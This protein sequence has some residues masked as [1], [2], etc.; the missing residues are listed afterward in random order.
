MLNL[1]ELERKLDLAL[2]NET[3]ESLT[4]WLEEKRLRTLLQ[5]LGNGT[6]DTIVQF[7]LNELSIKKESSYFFEVT[8]F[9]LSPNQELQSA[10]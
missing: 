1:I 7:K 3:T 10:A 8:D 6:F 2:A 9:T 5:S 4:N